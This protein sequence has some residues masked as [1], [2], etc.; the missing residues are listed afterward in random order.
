MSEYISTAQ[1]AM[2]CF[3][4]KSG[5]IDILTVVEKEI[6]IQQKRELAHMLLALSSDASLKGIEISF[7]TRASLRDLSIQ[8]LLNFTYRRQ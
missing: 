6:P 2:G 8:H 4:R 5:D 7:I 3:R 1:L